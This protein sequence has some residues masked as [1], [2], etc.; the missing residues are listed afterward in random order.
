MTMSDSSDIRAG[1]RTVSWDGTTDA[2]VI[3][4]GKIHTPWK[5]V[6]ECPRRGQLEGPLC[7]IELFDPWTE[8]LDGI[9]EYP[10]AEV[11]YWLHLSRRNLVRQSPRNNG[12]TFGAF[13][14]RT[15]NR[16]NPIG[17]AIVTLEGI[18]GRMIMVRGLD[19]LDGSPLLDLKP[20][21]DCFIP[22]APP[23]SGDV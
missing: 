11:L 13:S 14:L 20:D 2:G 5:T 23:T 6:F 12:T 21:R 8:A 10:Q 17:T 3:F 19:C 15:P 9:D 22:K 7:R 16:P 1:E 18:E 4:I